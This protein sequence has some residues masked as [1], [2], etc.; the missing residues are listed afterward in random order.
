MDLAGC[1]M[2]QSHMIADA[3]DLEAHHSS[4]VAASH[5][6]QSFSQAVS[7][8]LEVGTGM[9]GVTGNNWR[10]NQ[11]ASAGIASSPVRSC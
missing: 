4:P 10:Q 9:S 5:P 6:H 3:I 1:S 8:P 2:S 7:S 11:K